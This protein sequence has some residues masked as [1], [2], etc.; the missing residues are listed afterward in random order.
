MVGIIVSWNLQAVP[1]FKGLEDGQGTKLSC[2]FNF[3]FFCECVCFGLV[4]LI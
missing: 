4:I 1:P 2:P 3:I